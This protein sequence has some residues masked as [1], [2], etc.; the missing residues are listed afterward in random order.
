MA[1]R[2][3]AATGKKEINEK[4]VQKKGSGKIK[5]NDKV[6]KVSEK[7]IPKKK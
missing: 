5:E 1:R 2:T 6:V 7:K 3:K 4:K